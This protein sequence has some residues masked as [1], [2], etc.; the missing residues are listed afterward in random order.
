MTATIQTPT[1]YGVHQIHTME[2]VRKCFPR[3][4]DSVDGMNWL[5]TGTSGVH[6]SYTGAFNAAFDT[7]YESE[8]LDEVTPGTAKYDR[9]T[10]LVV[11]PRTVLMIYGSVLCTKDDVSW[12]RQVEKATVDLIAGGFGQEIEG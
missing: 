10:V 6:G 5:F 2:D 3:G 9:V 8:D 1:M 12:L 4:A 11:R 7:D